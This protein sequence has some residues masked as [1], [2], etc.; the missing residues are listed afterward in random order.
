SVTHP[1]TVRL[2]DI[3]GLGMGSSCEPSPTSTART[4]CPGTMTVPVGIPEPIGV[5]FAE[6]SVDTVVSE[7]AIALFVLRAARRMSSCAFSRWRS[8]AAAACAVFV[9]GSRAGCRS[10]SHTDQQRTQQ[11]GPGLENA[12]DDLQR[13]RLH[14]AA[15]DGLP[16]MLTCKRK[17]VCGVPVKEL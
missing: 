15:P 10:R 8:R 7:V 12:T 9:R 1:R 5:A 13:A 14:D 6:A 16:L 11:R 2:C 17:A 4:S 3:T